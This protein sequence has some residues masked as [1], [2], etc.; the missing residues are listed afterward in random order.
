MLACAL[1]IDLRPLKSNI[2]ILKSIADCVD[3]ATDATDAGDNIGELIKLLVA[4][5][6]QG[7]QRQILIYI[8]WWS[9]GAAIKY[10]LQSAAEDFLL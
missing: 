5:D 2:Y 3:T 6:L 8:F 4:G 7:A 10:G 1:G 9:L